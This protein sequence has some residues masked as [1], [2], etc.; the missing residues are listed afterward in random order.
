[1]VRDFGSGFADL[2]RP[3][4]DRTQRALPFSHGVCLTQIRLDINDIHKYVFDMGTKNKPGSYD[5]YE[6]AH[7]DEPMFV[8]LGRDPAAAAIV[9]LWTSL[10]ERLG[11]KDIGMLA[12]ASACANAMEAWAREHGKDPD[13]ANRELSRLI[14]GGAAYRHCC[15]TLYSEPR[16]G[17]GC[18]AVGHPCPGCSRRRGDTSTPK[19]Y[20]C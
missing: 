7:P 17:P 13:A 10:R 5:C 16:H 19:C 18:T 3:R 9:R 12:E 8:L 15:N 6:N 11:E 2:G 14:V 20:L 1:M 4:F